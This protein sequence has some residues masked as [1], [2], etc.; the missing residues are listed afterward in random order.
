MRAV[1]VSELCGPDQLRLGRAADPVADPGQARIV[2][3]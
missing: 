1:L 2:T 3:H